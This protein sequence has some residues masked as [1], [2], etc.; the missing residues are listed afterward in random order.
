MKVLVVGCGAGTQTAR[1]IINQ[2]GH[3]NIVFIE[4]ADEIPISEIDNFD[5]IIQPTKIEIP[6][7]I[8]MP[9]VPRAKHCKKGHERPY[10]YHR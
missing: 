6:K 2:L 8:D 9:F 1:E 5:K 7:L 10:K 4:K 3:D